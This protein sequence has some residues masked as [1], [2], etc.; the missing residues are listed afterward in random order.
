MTSVADVLVAVTYNWYRPQFPDAF[1]LDHWKVIVSL[2]DRHR[3]L[4]IYVIV[5]SFYQRMRHV[6]DKFS[7]L[8]ERLNMAR[9]VPDQQ[10]EWD[11]RSGVCFC[12]DLKGRQ[13][14]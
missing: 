1:V 7:I 9:R 3:E 12:L 2:W 5:L 6:V 11:L 14:R 4:S 8:L 10:E 13:E